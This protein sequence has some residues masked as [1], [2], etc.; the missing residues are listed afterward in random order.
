[1]NIA[2]IKRDALTDAGTERWN[3][4][5]HPKTND[6]PCTPVNKSTILVYADIKVR[7]ERNWNAQAYAFC[8][9][10]MAM[11]LIKQYYVT[12]TTIKWQIWKCVDITLTS[13]EWCLCH[14]IHFFLQY[15]TLCSGLGEVQTALQHQVIHHRLLHLYWW[16]WMGFYIFI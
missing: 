9:Y 2:L 15:V 14:S 6:S 16:N 12:F 7:H 10:R 5:K 4:S 11:F 1:M 3:L 13:G 8:Q